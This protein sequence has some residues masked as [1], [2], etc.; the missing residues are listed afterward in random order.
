MHLYMFYF[1]NLII[2]LIK[3]KDFRIYYEFFVLFQNRD[4]GETR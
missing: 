1:K 2:F 4:H 3:K